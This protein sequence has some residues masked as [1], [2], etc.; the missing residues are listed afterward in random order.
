MLLDK[1]RNPKFNN[2]IFRIIIIIRMS[3]FCNDFRQI[4]LEVLNREH[5]GNMRIIIKAC[6]SGT[7]FHYVTSFDTQYHWNTDF[8]ISVKKK[9]RV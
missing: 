1:S 8:K 7:V 2:V 4:N 3:F 5:F 9:Q 6:T